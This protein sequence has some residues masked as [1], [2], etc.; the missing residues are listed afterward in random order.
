VSSRVQPSAASHLTRFS[1]SCKD[2]STLGR[3]GDSLLRRSPDGKVVARYG[4]PWYLYWAKL[5]FPVMLAWPAAYMYL[6]LWRPG[7]RGKPRRESLSLPVSSTAKG[8]TDDN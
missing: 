1:F 4:T 7:W 2:G 3:H 5:P 8:R 6:A